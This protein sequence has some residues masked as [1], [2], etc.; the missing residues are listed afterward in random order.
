VVSPSLAPQA[1][2][3]G[4]VE[5]F[6]GMASLRNT[7]RHLAESRG[8]WAGVPM[9][10]AGCNLIIEPTYP[11]AQALMNIWKDEVV[12]VGKSDE[13]ESSAESARDPTLHF[14]NSFWSWHYRRE[15]IIWDVAGRVTWCKAPTTSHPVDLLLATLDASD[16]WGIEQ[17]RNAVD[18]LATLLPHRQF[19]QYLLTGLFM[20]KSQRSGVHYL[21][22]RLRPTLALSNN[23][24]TKDLKLLAALCLHPI[25]Y[26]EGSWA[27][28][29][30]PTDDVV[31]HL[32]L[33]RGDE[34]LFWR[35]ANQHPA[36]V[37]EAGLS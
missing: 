3:Y 35:R 9:P 5:K 22:R 24:R 16:A 26:Y 2:D 18:T 15:I 4:L 1:V 21:F 11:R 25:A 36:W 7:I 31:A 8:E 30:T 20:E 29:M 33:M 13:V 37:P 27:G 12:N 14:R 32:M 10:M 6:D 34:H 17:E 23:N 28:A 19:K